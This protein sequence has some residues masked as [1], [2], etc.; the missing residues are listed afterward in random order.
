MRLEKKFPKQPVDVLYS[1]ILKLR[2]WGVLLQEEDRKHFDKAC[3]VLELWRKE[4]IKTGEQVTATNRRSFLASFVLAT[5]VVDCS[6]R[7]S[8]APVLSS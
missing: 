3:D 1:I 5:T 7:P 2:N 6:K 8:L 4:F